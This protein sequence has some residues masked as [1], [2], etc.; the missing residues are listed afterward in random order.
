MA[1]KFDGSSGMKP[2]AEAR[3]YIYRVMA[4]ALDTDMTDDEGWVFGGIDCEFDRRR[5]REAA[6]RVR[7]DLLR[8]GS[9]S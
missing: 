3:R 2:S 8:K 6:K 5:L 9:F 7:A 1:T 4:T